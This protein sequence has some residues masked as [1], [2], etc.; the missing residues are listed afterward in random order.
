MKK[1]PM[2]AIAIGGAAILSLALGTA[3]AAYA[4][5]EHQDE[6]RSQAQPHQDSHQQPAPQQQHNQGQPRQAE[7]K[8]QQRTE[9][10]PAR[11]QYQPQQR[12]QEQPRQVQN[13][14]Q[15][16]VEQQPMPT[17]NQPQQRVQEQP[18]QIQSQPQQ[19]V[20]QQPRPAHDQ[21]LQRAQEQP[22]L[23]QP[24]P[25]QRN[26]QPGQNRQVENAQQQRGGVQQRAWQDH[27]AGNWQTDHRNWQQRGG[28]NGYRIPD[29]RFGG[30]FGVDHGFR[31]GGLPFMVVGGFP[32]FQYEG[33][34]FSMIDPWPGDWDDDW[35][36]TDDVYVS[37]MDNGYYLFNRRHPG[38]G[39]AIS[40]SM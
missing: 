39:I 37:Y 26:Q 25:V 1:S 3:G 31:I 13:Q 14:T 2:K 35:Y 6:K 22:R 23:V 15:Q 38:M 24:Q 4:V 29:A 19:R 21:P 30:Y 16:R 34:W 12:A 9:Q 33:Y 7:S 11:P 32:R 8:P 20:E 36:D 10:Q 5:Q 17:H 18:R 27:R 28:Y 40:V